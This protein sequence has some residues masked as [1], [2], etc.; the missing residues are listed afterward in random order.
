MNEM[1]MKSSNKSNLTQRLINTHTHAV[2]VSHME[3]GMEKFLFI[4]A[5]SYQKVC[6]EQMLSVKSRYVES[7][8]GGVGQ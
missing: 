8:I 5:T 1:K 7:S 4:V 3:L 6:D 2:G